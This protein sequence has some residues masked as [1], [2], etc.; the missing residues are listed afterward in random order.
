MRT[1]GSSAAQAAYGWRSVQVTAAADT[2]L[3]GDLRPCVFRVS[4]R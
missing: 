2:E 4:S 1:V 3:S